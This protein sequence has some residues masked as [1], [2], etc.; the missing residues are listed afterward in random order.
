[1]IDYSGLLRQLQA[2]LSVQHQKAFFV[3][4]GGVSLKERIPVFFLKMI[5]K[6][7]N[8]LSRY[9]KQYQHTLITIR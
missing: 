7:T 3:V 5:D 1:L 4:R 2:I 9:L 6:L 8:K